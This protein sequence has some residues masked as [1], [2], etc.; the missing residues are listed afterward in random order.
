MFSGKVFHICSVLMSTYFRACF[1]ISAWLV[2]LVHVMRVSRSLKNQ[3]SSRGLELSNVGV[4]CLL[5]IGIQKEVSIC[6]C[7]A[8]D[9]WSVG[10]CGGSISSS[11]SNGWSDCSGCSDSKVC[12]GDWIV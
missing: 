7:D 3:G 1:F 6:D 2:M 5:C 12:Q 9:G 8:V 10:D 4:A 11:S